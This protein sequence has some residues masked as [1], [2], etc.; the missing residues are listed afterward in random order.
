MMRKK[1]DGGVRFKA[2]LGI[3]LSVLFAPLTN[4]VGLLVMVYYRFRVVFCF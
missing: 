3:A 1:R 2:I 4:P